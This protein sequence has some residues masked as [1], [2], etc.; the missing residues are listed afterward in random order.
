MHIIQVLMELMYTIFVESWNQYVYHIWRK[1]V[2]MVE[3]E[4][5]NITLQLVYTLGVFVFGTITI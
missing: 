3:M 1:R 4:Y 5:K 2:F